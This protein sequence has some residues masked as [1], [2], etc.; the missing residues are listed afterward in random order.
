MDKAPGSKF[1]CRKCKYSKPDV[2]ESFVWIPEN[3]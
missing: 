2:K 1:N 3:P